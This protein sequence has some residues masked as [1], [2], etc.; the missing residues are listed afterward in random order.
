MLP[1]S[2]RKPLKLLVC[3]EQV[4]LGSKCLVVVLVSVIF[5]VALNVV[6][7]LELL[8]LR[9]VGEKVKG[10]KR[11]K[12]RCKRDKRVKMVRKG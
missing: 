11:V 12:T 9:Q 1:Y 3:S 6:A 7:Q 8:L 4:H 10:D 2:T 5:D